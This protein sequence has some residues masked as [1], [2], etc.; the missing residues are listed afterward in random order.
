MMALLLDDLRD[1]SRITRG[2]L[3]LRKQFAE[4][5][6]IIDAAVEDGS[7][8]LGRAP[9]RTLLSLAT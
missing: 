6:T 8:H 4:L 7:T 2:T 1:I 5:R 9:A 3:E